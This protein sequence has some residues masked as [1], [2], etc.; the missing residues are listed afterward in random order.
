M[1]RWDAHRAKAVFY[2]QIKIRAVNADKTMRGF[3]LLLGH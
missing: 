1:S 2:A 3:C